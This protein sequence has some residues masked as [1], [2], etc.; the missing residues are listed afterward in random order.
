MAPDRLRFDFIHFK[1]VSEVEMGRIEEMLNEKIRENISVMTEVMDVSQALQSG[2]MAL[3]GEKYG[4]KVR[5]VQVPGFSKELC[6]GTHCK[7]TGD[8]GVF[9]ITSESGIAAGVRRIEALT[10][11]A[12]LR[13]F[14]ESER[15]VA[16]ISGMLKAKPGEAAGK[17]ERLVT[18]FKEQEKEIARLKGQLT[19][20]KAKDISS[21]IQEVEG[22]KVLSKRADPM[23]IDDLR[24]F[25]ESLR[26]QMKSGVVAAGTGADE[27]AA[28]VVMVTKDL[29]SRL[30]AREI[31]RE[32][33]PLV[34]GR[35]G[36]RADM[37]QA[38]GKRPEGLAEALGKVAGVVGEMA[39]RGK[40]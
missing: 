27:K 19:V 18:Q 34:D 10:G 4:E 14:I 8:I 21:E 1:P 22:I 13:H 29:A 6:G 7:A 39:K 36:G 11:A 24:N 35:G 26:S 30:D 15:T 20:S 9:R 16:E 12:A 3:F 31:I 32:I 23:S 2:A 38:G 5:V 40:T 28:I 17:A 25:A 33:A 37:A